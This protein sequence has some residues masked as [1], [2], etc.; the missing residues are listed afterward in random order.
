MARLY[1]FARLIA[2]FSREK[3]VLSHDD[4]TPFSINLM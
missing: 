3:G 2:E 4:K 1:T